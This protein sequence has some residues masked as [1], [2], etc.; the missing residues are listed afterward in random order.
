MTEQ[1]STATSFT[2]REALVRTR[3]WL[4]A[5]MLPFFWQQKNTSPVPVYDG[6]SVLIGG[7]PWQQ[8][9]AALGAGPVREPLPSSN[10]FS[11]FVDQITVSG[12]IVKMTWRVDIQVRDGVASAQVYSTLP[13]VDVEPISIEPFADVLAVAT[14]ILEAANAKNLDF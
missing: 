9:E 2:P 5:E 7:S 13:R 10:E 1:D 12:P 11:L 8:A 6:K 3:V 4:F 14:K